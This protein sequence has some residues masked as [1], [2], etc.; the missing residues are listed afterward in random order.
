MHDTIDTAIK[1]IEDNPP[2]GDSFTLDIANGATFMGLPDPMGAGFAV[3]L[4][5]ILNC[6]FEPDGLDHFDGFRRY[7][8][9]RS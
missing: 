5:T 9:V 7:K 2:E 1:L 4:A 8:Y 3:L 6:G